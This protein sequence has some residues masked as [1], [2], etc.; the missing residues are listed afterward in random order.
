MTIGRKPGIGHKTVRIL[1]ETVQFRAEMPALS[2]R[3]GVKFKGGRRLV[4]EPIAHPPPPSLVVFRDQ[5]VFDSVA[6]DLVANRYRARVSQ[7][8]S[9]HDQQRRPDLSNVT[10]NPNLISTAPSVHVFAMPAAWEAAHI[11]L[12]RI[13]MIAAVG[14]FQLRDDGG[15]NLRQT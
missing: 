1:G 14:G 7:F 10:L 12:L 13:T 5:V 4:E 6:I 15:P 9:A 3:R 2:L 11:L 8:K